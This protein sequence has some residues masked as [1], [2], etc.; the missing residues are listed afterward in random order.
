MDGA[1]FDASAGRAFNSNGEGSMSVIREAS[2]TTF[3]VVETALTRRGARTMILD[4][5][6]HRILVLSAKFGGYPTFCQ[7]PTT[8][9]L[10]F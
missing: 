7:S 6:T 3:S 9:L 8:Y 2:P 4:D 1:G 10:V 5:N